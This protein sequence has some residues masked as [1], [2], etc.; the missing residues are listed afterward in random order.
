ME[1]G[2]D[3]G[4]PNSFSEEPPQLPPR[5]EG[6]VPRAVIPGHFPLLRMMP[7]LDGRDLSQCWIGPPTEGERPF[8][9]E[10]CTDEVIFLLFTHK[11]TLNF[12]I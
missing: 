4:M 3:D 2:A 9:S 6:P 8:R 11:F 5:S 10:D 12:T 7:P 1:G